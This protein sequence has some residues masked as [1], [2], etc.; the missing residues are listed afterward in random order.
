MRPQSHVAKAH[1]DQ[2]QR[3]CQQPQTVTAPRAKTKHQRD[4]NNACINL[5]GW[6]V[7][8]EKIEPDPKAKTHR[9]PGKQMSPLGL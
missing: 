8:H 7:R 6:F 5:Q 3:P 4:R 2:D 9:N 1:T